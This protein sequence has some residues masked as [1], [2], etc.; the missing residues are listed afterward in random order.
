MFG[1]VAVI[2]GVLGEI[3]VASAPFVAV[4]GAITISAAIID[5]IITEA[6]KEIERELNKKGNTIRSLD[7][8]YKKNK[9][10][11]QN[12]INLLEKIKNEYEIQQIKNEITHKELIVS[13][14]NNILNESNDRRDE[15]INL[16]NQ[17]LVLINDL[18]SQI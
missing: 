17:L 2:L 8:I 4:A 12:N 1:L 9:E 10:N 16:R 13:K 3:A 14:I 5:D 11:F 6:N 7:N 15:L 18:K